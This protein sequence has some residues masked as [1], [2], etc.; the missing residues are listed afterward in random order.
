MS[1][2]QLKHAKVIPNFVNEHER[3]LPLLDFTRALFQGTPLKDVYLIGAQ[4]ILSSTYT[5]LQHLMEKGL[6][7][8]NISLIGKCYSTNPSTFQMMVETG[9][10]VCPSSQAFDY[11]KSFDTEYRKHM[12]EFLKQR[13]E[14]I[15]KFKK[16]IVLDDGGELLALASEMFADSQCELVGVEQTTAGFE[17]LK[18]KQLGFPIVNV[19]RS[20]AKLNYESPF[21]VRI[22]MER[23]FAHFLRLPIHKNLKNI[24]IIGNGAIGS[25]IHSFLKDKYDVTIFDTDPTKSQISAED[26]KSS[27]GEFDLIVG[28]TGKKT[29]QAHHHPLLKKG[30]ILMS[31]SSSDREFDA[32]SL[33][34]KAKKTILDCHEDLYIDDI[35][36]LNC[37][38]PV[39]FDD[40]YASVDSDELQ[41]TRSLL[42]SAILQAATNTVDYSG[43]INLNEDHQHMIIREYLHLYPPVRSERFSTNQRFRSGVHPN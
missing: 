20:W 28:C 13:Y 19:A 36:L 15:S 21:I 26:F 39:N 24:L 40:D 34:K 41:L 2:S 16:I 30:V 10:D 12:K 9:I 32:E 22:A 33:R 6:S 42:F 23:F 14:T 3:D 25:N 5:L 27:L 8:S 37:G 43:F 1:T 31:V 29:I 35:C 38:F 18:D 4:H 7:K 17:K 11:K